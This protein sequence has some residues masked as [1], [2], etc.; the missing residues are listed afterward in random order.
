M[1]YRKEP[2]FQE[3]KDWLI[4]VVNA[5][6]QQQFQT[7]TQPLQ[8]DHGVSASLVAGCGWLERE[9]GIVE[10]SGVRHAV[11]AQPEWAVTT[12]CAVD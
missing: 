4:E 8:A 10:L 11:P 7:C 9:R 2:D 1:F 5:V 3:Q 6:R 12:A